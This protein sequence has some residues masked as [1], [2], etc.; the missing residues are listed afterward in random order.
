VE[1]AIFEK[2]A[3]SPWVTTLLAVMCFDLKRPNLKE[4]T[5]LGQA[6]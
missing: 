5:S 4:S 6:M 2:V 1:V 3:V